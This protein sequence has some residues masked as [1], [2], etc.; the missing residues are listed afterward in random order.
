MRFVDEV[1]FKKVAVFTSLQVGFRV[2]RLAKSG[3]HEVVYKI[4]KVVLQDTTISIRILR[5]DAEKGEV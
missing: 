2:V 1:S 3:V 5:V 4:L